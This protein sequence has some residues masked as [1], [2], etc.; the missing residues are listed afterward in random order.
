MHNLTT[1]Q[2]EPVA[3]RGAIVLL[4]MA[5]LEYLKVQNVSESEV[6]LVLQAIAFL[7]GLWRTRAKVMPVAVVKEAGMTPA[8][9]KAMAA[10]PD[11]QR[12]A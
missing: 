8:D 10:D 5:A 11:I 6:V 7:V 1:V 9:V 4:I 12:A 2:T 3:I